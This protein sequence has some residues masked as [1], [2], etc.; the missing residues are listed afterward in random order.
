MNN[1]K[2]T[3]YQRSKHRSA[4]TKRQRALLTLKTR[5]AKKIDKLIKPVDFDE[6]SIDKSAVQDNILSTERKVKGSELA[7]NYPNK[8]DV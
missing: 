6:H 2:W 3:R 5:R 7:V 1:E 4:W 8:T